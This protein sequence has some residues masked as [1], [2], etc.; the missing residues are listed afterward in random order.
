MKKAIWYNAN[1][2]YLINGLNSTISQGGTLYKY[3][4]HQ[5]EF[6]HVDIPLKERQEIT[7]VVIKEN[8]FILTIVT[9]DKEYIEFTYD[10]MIIEIED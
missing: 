9:F 1:T 5:K 2:I 8:K 7:N 10:E 4:I 3:S 6:E